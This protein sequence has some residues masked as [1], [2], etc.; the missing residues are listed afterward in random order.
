MGYLRA[1][2]GDVPNY[3][4]PAT[5]QA[6]NIKGLTSRSLRRIRPMPRSSG[7]TTSAGTNLVRVRRLRSWVDLT[8]I[9]RTR[10]TAGLSLGEFVHL[11]RARHLETVG[12]RH[13][14]DTDEYNTIYGVAAD[15]GAPFNI[16]RIN[17]P[18]EFLVTGS[19]RF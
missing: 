6:I 2:W 5:S 13:Q 9:L 15:V 4:N 19:V 8:G 10:P 17:R 3:I 18:R 12:Q 1:K 7:S 11:G 14:S 16:A